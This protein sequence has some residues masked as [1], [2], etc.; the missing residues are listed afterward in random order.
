LKVEKPNW[1]REA[2]AAVI[3]GI[4]TLCVTLA[5]IIMYRAEKRRERDI[6]ASIAANE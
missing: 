5:G 1:S 6:Q 3:I 2:L 4:V